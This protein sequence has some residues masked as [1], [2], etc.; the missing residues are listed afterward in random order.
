MQPRRMASPQILEGGIL[1]S[2][3][4]YPAYLS[5]YPGKGGTPYNGLYRKALCQTS[6]IL[7][8]RGWKM[9]HLQGVQCSKLECERGT[10]WQQKAYKRCPFSVKN[11]I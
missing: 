10:I 1:C 8:G 7:K 4:V 3:Y 9:G 5:M 6:G 2:S 11:G